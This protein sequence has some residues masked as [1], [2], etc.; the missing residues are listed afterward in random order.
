[1]SG[2]PAQPWPVFAV[3]V[4]IAAVVLP[5][6]GL[7]NPALEAAEPASATTALAEN[8]TSAAKPT[9]PAADSTTESKAEPAAKPKVE[10][11]PDSDEASEKRSAGN[12]IAELTA[13]VRK[14]LV[15]I[16]VRGRDGH[17]HG[18]GT[19]FVVS[20]D[21]LIAT[22][23]HVIGEA[24]P[25]EVR[26]AE[27]RRLQ[28][29]AVHATE[30]TADLALLKVDAAD[31]PPLPLG[32]SDKLRQGQEVVAMGNPLGLEF[33]VV[34][35]IVSGRRTIDGK[36]LIQLAIPIEP[37]NSGGPLIDLDG[38]VQ[39]ILTLKSLVSE[40]LGFAVEINAL[41]P[42]L[43][44]PNPVPIERWLTI[45][46]LDDREWT[47]KFGARW[48]QRHGHIRVEGRGAGFGG[49]S[50]CLSN[51]KLPDRPFEIGVFV[52]LDQEDGAAGLV[53]HADGGD[54]HYG[55]Y[56]SNGQMRLSRFDGPDVYSWQVLE[57]VRTP[58]YHPGEWNH[59]KVRIEKDRIL[60][61]VNDELVI[62]SADSQYTTGKAG[63]AK[64]RHTEA[65]FRGFAVGKNLP[66]TQPSEEVVRRVATL[67]QGL[68]PDRPARSELVEQLAAEDAATVRALDAQARLLERRAERLKQLARSVHEHR[69]RQKLLR[70][71]EAPPAEVDLLRAALLIA[72]LDNPDLPLESYIRAVE[73]MA[74]EIRQSLPDQADAKTRLEALNTYLFDQLG[75][76]G[77][78]TEYYHRSNSYL[79][80][81]IDDREGLPIT[82]A[83]LYM[84]LGRRLGL[85]LEGVGL[86]GHF[87][88][89]FIPGKEEPPVLID[90]FDRGRRLTRD[91][92]AEKVRSITGLELDEAHL[93][94]QSPRAIVQRMLRNLFGV[95]RDELDAE[96]M[97]RYT[98]TLVALDPE[99][100]QDRWLRAVL[101]FQTDR[102][103]AAA[104]DVRWLMERHPENVD[105]EL[106]RQL[107]RAIDEQRQ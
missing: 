74:E 71:L 68:D 1:M 47:P 11:T 78:R 85:S 51:R 33:S 4:F 61:F 67:T 105:M 21:G 7:S 5:A 87:V 83:V 63:L 93:A 88:V 44:K 57:Q 69:V 16:T 31:L 90:V 32:D 20:G 28:V 22:N 82:L 45:G 104:D 53:F 42:L 29:T 103:D 97:L 60:C 30:T 77:S 58:H 36:P 107:Q 26:T 25:I 41:K 84:E 15:T 55:F 94:A 96:A 40:N 18:L 101:R 3:M 73:R 49:R 23:L 14:S 76:H 92:A 100:A 66:P 38:N 2:R 8:P 70:V 95:A 91:Q 54:R 79:N 75:F 56:P 52:K 62:E 48:M 27:G 102:L 89:R 9:S 80:E 6:A 72:K 12:R 50:L 43:A 64:F 46:S 10:S 65:E 34:R 99:A 86:P 35:G 17:R 39:G 106:V 24:R 59:L 37:G 13:R 98:E 19:G 81:V